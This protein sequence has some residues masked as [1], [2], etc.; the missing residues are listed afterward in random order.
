MS[1]VHCK[2]Y[3]KELDALAF[4]PLPGELG[5]K[6]QAEISQQAWQAWLAHQTILIN[7]YRLNLIDPKSKEFLKEEMHKFLFE[8]KEEKPE[9]FTKL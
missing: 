1:K 9:Q 5:K 4:Q 2:K 3:D 8:G 6:I 7:E